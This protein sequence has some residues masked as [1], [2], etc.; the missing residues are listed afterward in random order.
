METDT[1][2]SSATVVPISLR[3][4]V[5][6][7]CQNRCL[8]CTPP[9][10]VKLFPRWRVLRY[11]QILRFVQIIKK[12]FGLQKLR[13]TGGEPLVRSGIL[14]FVR[15]LANEGIEDIAMTTNGL[16][17]AEHALELARAGLK[18]VTVSL[19]SIAVETYRRISRG[20]DVRAVLAGIEAAAQG[21]LAPIKLNATLLRGINDNEAVD[22]VEFAI[23]RG[24]RLRFIELMPI[25]EGA[26]EFNRWFVSS[27]EVLD[28]LGQESEIK[29]L[30]RK[31]GSTSREFSVKTSA[32]QV[33]IIG[34]ISSASQPFCADCNRLR[35]T[36]TGELIGCLANGLG[37]S[38]FPL[39]AT[40]GAVDEAQVVRR[41]RAVM[42]HK[43]SD[44]G[45]SSRR[46]MVKVGG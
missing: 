18:R 43:R 13:I 36:A 30:P 22:L 41:V 37:Q 3:V 46:N 10:G 32:G 8:Y 25:G 17:L 11:E 7:L 24:F 29:A 5:T 33:G 38:I 26:K 12:H 2:N 16:A 4:S 9:E 19:D 39:L 23:S 35:L 34:V 14:D 21:N 31:V 42:S 28:R 1:L 27:Q 45:F 40:A 6:D 44:R 20:G 15:M